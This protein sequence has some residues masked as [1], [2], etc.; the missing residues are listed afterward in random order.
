MPATAAA[1]AAATSALV[2][3]V[4]TAELL[5]LLDFALTAGVATSFVGHRGILLQQR[6][7]AP[8]LSPNR[9]S[10]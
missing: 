10:N 5:A 6:R 8:A 9:M 3:T 4:W 7:E 2:G 1:A